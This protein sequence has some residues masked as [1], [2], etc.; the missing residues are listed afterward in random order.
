MKHDINNLPDTLDHDGDEDSVK[1]CCFH[2]SPRSGVFGNPREV[3]DY[4]NY[5]ST[6]VTDLAEIGSKRLV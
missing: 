4:G 1:S 3:V 5:F 2:A 6:L